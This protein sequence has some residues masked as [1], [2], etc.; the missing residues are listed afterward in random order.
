MKYSSFCNAFYCIF[1]SFLAGLS[2]WITEMR[3]V[4]E[5]WDELKNY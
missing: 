5:G 1:V 3:N 2:E 4:F